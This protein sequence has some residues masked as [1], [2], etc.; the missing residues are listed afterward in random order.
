MQFVVCSVQCLVC[1]VQCAVCS[2][3]CVVFSVQ[4]AVYSAQCA[5]QCPV[6]GEHYTLYYIRKSGKKL[7]YFNAICMLSI[8][9]ILTVIQARY[10]DVSELRLLYSKLYVT[11]HT[12]PA[13]CG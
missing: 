13:D 6:F 9:S 3:D 7:C 2:V 11:A 4:C 10:H 12:A 8:L 5:D 1:S